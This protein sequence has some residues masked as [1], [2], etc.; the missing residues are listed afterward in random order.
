MSGGTLATGSPADVT[1]IDPK[2]AWTCEPNRLRSRSRNTPF[3]GRSM[4]GRAM[5]TI[6]EGNI[7]FAEEKLIG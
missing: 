4:R 2:A 3:G 6:V 7:V 5:L 1:V